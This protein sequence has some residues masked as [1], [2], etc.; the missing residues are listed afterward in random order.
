ME[1]MDQINIYT[2]TSALPVVATVLLSERHRGFHKYDLLNKSQF[3][4]DVYQAVHPRAQDT[5]VES[6]GGLEGV[7]D[8]LIQGGTVRRIDD[9]DEDI[10]YFNTK[11]KVRL[12][13]YKNIFVHHYVIPSI[14]ALSLRHGMKKREELLENILFFDNLLRHEFM[15]P[16]SFDFTEAVNTMLNFS[17]AHSLVSEQNGDLLP[18]PAK[19]KELNILANIVLPFLESFH[20]AIDSL[21]SKKVVYPIDSKKLVTIFRENHQKLLLLGRIN[22]MEGNLT[23]SY[24]NIIRFFTEEKV[25]EQQNTVERKS[26][27]RTGKAFETIHELDQKLFPKEQLISN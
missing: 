3:L 22:S 4:V 6:E 11:N 27:I 16:R 17:L 18:N 21:T 2:R 26:I 5:L 14:I 15:F 7:V 10:F 25:L 24:Q 13:L 9:P 23:V 8:F 12:N 1:V 20:V 19:M